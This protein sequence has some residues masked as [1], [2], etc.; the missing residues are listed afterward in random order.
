MTL[1][2]T[3]NMYEDRTSIRR[4]LEAYDS[5]EECLFE[6]AVLLDCGTTVELTFN[7]VR[8]DIGEIRNDVLV[9][10][11]PVV[12][13]LEVVQG[14]HVS[15]D[16]TEA[17]LAE[18]ARLNWGFQEI[19][20]VELEESSRFLNNYEAITTAHFHHLSVKWEG[21]RRIDTVFLRLGVVDMVDHKG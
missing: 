21:G 17:M 4:E 12:L 13:R 20:L 3:E 16:L 7:Y 2:Y 11:H 6:G 18:P 1:M 5:F 14:F 9:S 8:D 15:N 10:P 19:A